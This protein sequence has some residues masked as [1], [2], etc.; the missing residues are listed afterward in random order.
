MVE[1][2]SGMSPVVRTVRGMGTYRTK[3]RGSRRRISRQSAADGG[4]ARE[5][6]ARAATRINR[7]TQAGRLRVVR[8][9]DERRRNEEGCGDGRTEVE[10][11]ALESGRTWQPPIL[12][13]V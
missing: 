13:I 10:G 7:A 1:G 9:A 2:K 6:G 11:S 12:S 4:R 5:R 8:R 3:S